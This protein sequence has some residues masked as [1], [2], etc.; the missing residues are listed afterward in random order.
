MTNRIWTVIGA[1]VVFFV[2]FLVASVYQ[3][4][5]LPEEK[6]GRA[7]EVS[8]IV[9]MQVKS[10]EGE[11]WAKIN[12][13]VVDTS[14]HVAFTL[15]SYG[16]KLVA[17]PFGTLSYNR[18]GKH[19]VLNTTRDRLESAPAYE[20][21]VMADRKKAEGIYR[22]FGQQP[23]WYEEGMAVQEEGGYSPTE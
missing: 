20:K 3:S 15:L 13:V 2:G 6:F 5:R 10:P 8:E 19:L 11:E 12:D 17:V 21:G 9:G 16:D 22:H 18:E 23:Y 7:Y 1:V 4:A 14:G